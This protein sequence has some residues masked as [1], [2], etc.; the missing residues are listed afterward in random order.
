MA[1]VVVTKR[2]AFSYRKRKRELRGAGAAI[3]RGQSESTPADQST[4]EHVTRTCPVRRRVMD[5]GD[6]G[7]RGGRRNRVAQ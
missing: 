2:L 4:P 5:A 6:R 7:S 3:E 1:I